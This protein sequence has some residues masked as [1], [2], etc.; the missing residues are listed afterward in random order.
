MLKQFFWLNKHWF[1]LVLFVFTVI[2][3]LYILIQCK[4]K[5]TITRHC[6]TYIVF[7]YKGSQLLSPN[8]NVICEYKLFVCYPS[9]H[10][11]LNRLFND[12]SGVQKIFD[13]NA[14][15]CCLHC[16]TENHNTYI[17][18]INN[19]VLKVVPRRTS[20]IIWL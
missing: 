12:I 10:E 17:W 6:S 7:I 14:Y 2:M 9:T 19:H 11:F 5:R 8:L 1:V 3:T 15:L 20:I 18:Y 13:Q 16:A 4:D